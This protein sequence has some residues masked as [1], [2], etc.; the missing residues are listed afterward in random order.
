MFHQ[1]DGKLPH[2]SINLRTYLIPQLDDGVMEKPSDID[3]LIYIPY[4]DTVDDAK[5]NLAKEMNK[6]GLSIDLNDL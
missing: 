4:A 6:Q 5:V 3:G 2:T 1:R